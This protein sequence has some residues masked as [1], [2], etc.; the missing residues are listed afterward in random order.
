M[1]YVKDRPIA[2]FSWSSAPR[3]IGAR[4]RYIGWTKQNRDKHLSLMAY[5]SSM[6]EPKQIKLDLDE[7]DALLKRVE[8]GHLQDGDY[9]IIKSMAETIVF[10]NQALENKKVSIKWGFTAANV[11]RSCVNF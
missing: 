4:D 9:E 11:N 7:I 6:K 2:C 5:N 3:H 1:V 8:T 10:L